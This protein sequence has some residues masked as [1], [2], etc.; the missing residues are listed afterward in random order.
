MLLHRDECRAKCMPA[1][2]TVND[3]IWKEI[4]EKNAQ[5]KADN[6]AFWEAEQVFRKWQNEDRRRKCAP[7]PLLPFSLFTPLPKITRWWMGELTAHAISCQFC[8]CGGSAG[9]SA[10]PSPLRLSLPSH[11]QGLYI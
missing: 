7:P 11:R 9:A 3:L 10:L 5:F 6:D 8:L 2:R 4:Q 1:C